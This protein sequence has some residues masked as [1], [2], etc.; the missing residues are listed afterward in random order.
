MESNKS[1][2]ILRITLIS[3]AVLRWQLVR[4]LLSGLLLGWLGPAA[5]QPLP[6]AAPADTLAPVSPALV[7][8]FLARS[9]SVPGLVAPNVPAARRRALLLWAGQVGTRLAG[10]LG[11]WFYTPESEEDAQ[12]IID[13]LRRSIG[14]LHAQNPDIAAQGCIFEIVWPHVSRLAVPNRLRATFG[15]DTLAVP[16]RKFRFA[17]MMYPAYFG[18]DNTRHYRWD[19]RPPGQAPGTPDFTQP[20]A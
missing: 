7:Q 4:L 19:E 15:E 10:R 3:S 14:V 9:L 12:V 17:D 6:P 18:E 11:G 8:H 16:Q 2:V 20:E 1:K 5:A 13:T